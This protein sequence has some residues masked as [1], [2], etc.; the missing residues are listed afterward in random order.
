MDDNLVLDD[1]ELEALQILYSRP[2]RAG[3]RYRQVKE[4]VKALECPPVAASTELLWRA[5]EAV[6]PKAVSGHGG[7][8]V[9]VIALVRHAIDPAQVLKPFPATVEER[10]QGWLADQQA[11]G[12]V[13][14]L[15][16]RRWLNAIKD[17][18][19]NSASIEQDDLD[20]VPFNQMGGQGK[21]YDLFGDRL[22][23]ILTELNVRLAT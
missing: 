23:N 20:S 16:Q 10:Y 18:I 7:K 22:E 5:F 13:F 14:T 11:A 21:A 2:Y 12:V 15:E 17:H 9:D 3:L 6:E 4:L 19:A 1:N 8:L